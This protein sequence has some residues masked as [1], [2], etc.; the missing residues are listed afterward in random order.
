MKRKPISSKVQ[1]MV[2]AISIA[3]LIITSAVGIF[4]MIRIQNDSENA[5]IVQMEQ[6]LRN[7]ALSK[8]DLADSELGKF[9][10]YVSNFATYINGLYKNPSAYVSHDVPTPKK[11]DAGKLIIQR[12]LRDNGIQSKDVEEKIQ[13]LKSKKR[14]LVDSVISVDRNIAKTLT[15]QDIKDI[16]SV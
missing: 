8:A 16:F 15:F 14:S 12:T 1:N 7:I 13:R 10:V 9:S 4:S 3:A 5:L 6:N 11:E 2:L